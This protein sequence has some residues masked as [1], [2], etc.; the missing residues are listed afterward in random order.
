MKPRRI[1]GAMLR[2]LFLTRHS[3][4]RFV[5]A[6]YYP[7]LDLTVWGLTSSYF[8][9]Q[10]PTQQL[11]GFS[12][13]SNVVLWYVIFIS[14]NEL[15]ANLLEDCHNR[16]LVN[17]F[18]TP[19]KF[20]E[21]VG[22]FM[23]LSLLK[24]LLAFFFS[25]MLAYLLFQ[26][27]VFSYGPALLPFFLNLTILGWGI[28]FFV[29]CVLLRLGSKA[30]TLAWAMAYL[31]YPFSAIFYPLE[32]LPAWGQTLAALIP[33]SH[34][35]EGLRSLLLTHVFPLNQFIW[36]LL[37]NLFYLALSLYLFHRSFKKALEKG[38]IKVF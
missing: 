19:L 22:G 15:G 4:T 25:A 11:W 30:G 2:Y 12:I 17:L 20:S 18:G 35:F 5:D 34:I 6:F 3:L 9:L 8:H 21:W 1:Y 36:A 14:N 16:N 10:D 24:S 33:S 31:I 7:A 23:L 29:A 27:N 28:G 13:V 26:V 32:I 38:L 37:L